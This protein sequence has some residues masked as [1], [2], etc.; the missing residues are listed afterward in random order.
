MA[1][2]QFDFRII[3]RAQV[4][5]SDGSLPERLTPLTA[6]S[7]AGALVEPSDE[8][9]SRLTAGLPLAWRSES[10]LRVYG[11]LEGNRIDLMSQHEKIDEVRVRL[12]LRR[13]DE[14]VIKRALEYARATDSI[15]LTQELE[16]VEPLQSSLLKEIEDS[17]AHRFLV[18]PG[19]YLDSRGVVEP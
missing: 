3:P 16:I 1:L 8:R 7:L 14:D 15:L 5:G 13:I 10:G 12:D 11:V 9:L 18:D 17:S 4:Q 2:W 6:D 19:P